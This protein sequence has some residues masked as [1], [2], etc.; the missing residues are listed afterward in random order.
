MAAENFHAWKDKAV[1]AVIGL[2]AAILGVFATHTFTEFQTEKRTI[3]EHTTRIA[4]H[5]KDL[6]HVRINIQDLK[7]S[8]KKTHEKLDWL[9]QNNKR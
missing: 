3:S 7:E 5:E 6:D 2:L 4:E 8:V 9:I 1:T